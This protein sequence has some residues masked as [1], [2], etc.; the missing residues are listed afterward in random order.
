MALM[1]LKFRTAHFV[2][3]RLLQ[4]AADH[5]GAVPSDLDINFVN[6]RSHCNVVS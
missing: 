5:E 4:Y 3:G 2:L 1:R 6:C